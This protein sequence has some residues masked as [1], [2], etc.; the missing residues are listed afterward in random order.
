MYNGHCAQVYVCVCGLA[1]RPAMHA[2]QSAGMQLG[3]LVACT[4][5]RKFTKRISKTHVYAHPMCSRINL[6]L[7]L[8]HATS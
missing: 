7:K 8:I 1:V 6:N 5:A 4:A 2:A 3:K